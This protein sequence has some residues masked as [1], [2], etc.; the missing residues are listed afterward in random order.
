[1][2][3]SFN[4]PTIEIGTRECALYTL[5]NIEGALAQLREVRKNVRGDHKHRIDNT[6]AVFN[7]IAFETK[8]MF[9]ITDAEAE[10]FVRENRVNYPL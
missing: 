6:A 5:A 2:K 7:I 3:K 1:M 9:A 10:T 8:Q 4:P